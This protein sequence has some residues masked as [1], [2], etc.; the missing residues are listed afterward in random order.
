MVGTEHVA[1]NIKRDNTYI[2]NNIIYIYSVSDVK[3]HVQIPQPQWS[4]RRDESA[5][6]IQVNTIHIT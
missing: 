5:V 3:F 2:Y 6:F 1:A 4:V